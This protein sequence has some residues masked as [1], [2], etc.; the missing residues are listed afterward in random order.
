MPRVRSTISLLGALLLGAACTAAPPGAPR[1]EHPVTPGPP[2]GAP[3]GPVRLALPPSALTEDQ[4][5][6]HAVNR[7]AY[8]P[9]PGDVEQVRRLGLRR[10]IEQQLS[11][12]S[13]PDDALEARLR[14]LLT[15]PMTTPEL[16]RQYPPPETARRDG[17]LWVR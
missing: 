7:L 11:P 16:L 8:G 2:P 3:A 12:E 15:L 1:T 10:W 13:V 6:V 5:I 9:R 14:D 4:R 17:R